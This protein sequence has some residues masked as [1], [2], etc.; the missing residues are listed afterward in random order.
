M[1]P[2]VWKYQTIAD[3]GASGAMVEWCGEVKNF[4]LSGS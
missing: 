1:L 4:R 3:F 2:I